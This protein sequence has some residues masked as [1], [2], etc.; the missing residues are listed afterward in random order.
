MPAYPW[1]YKKD[2][3]T[4]DISNRINALRTVGVQ[5]PEGYEDQALADL[6]AQAQTVVDD[7]AS[8]G[9]AEIDGIDVTSDKQIIALIAYLQR[10]GIDIK[11]KRDPFEGL[12]SKVK[13]TDNQD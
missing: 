13:L 6:E 12:P 11:G 4:S 9:F 5:Y 10:V 8:N 7:L 1:L 2:M 3:K